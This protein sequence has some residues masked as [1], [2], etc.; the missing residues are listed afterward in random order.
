MSNIYDDS[1]K[2]QSE[3]SSGTVAQIKVMGIGGGGNNAINRMINAN[4]RSAQFIAVNTDKQALYLSKANVKIQIGEKLTRGLGAGGE[5]EIGAKAAEESR[6]A[7]VE[8]VRGA[9]LLFITAAWRRHRNGRSAR[10][11]GNR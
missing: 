3:S 8:A 5:P 11:C 6:E 9:D 7:L 2:N 1:E 10:Y 4:I